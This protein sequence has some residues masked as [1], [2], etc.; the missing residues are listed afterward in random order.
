MDKIKALK[1]LKRLLEE[2]LITEEDF[3]RQKK[4]ILEEESLLNETL[5]SESEKAIDLTNEC[6]EQK[7][8]IDVPTGKLPDKRISSRLIWGVVIGV[9][10]I[11]GVV[12]GFTYLRQQAYG[13][14]VDYIESSQKAFDKMLKGLEKSDSETEIA[15]RIY[16]RLYGLLEKQDFD[17]VKLLYP[18]K[19]KHNGKEISREEVMSFWRRTVPVEVCYRDASSYLGNIV[20][21]AFDEVNN[22]SDEY[23]HPFYIKA[24]RD[25]GKWR[26][27]EEGDDGILGPE[28]GPDALHKITPEG[29]GPIKLGMSAPSIPERTKWMYDHIKNDVDNSD[30]QMGNVFFYDSSG[31]ILFTANIYKNKIIGLSFRSPLFK[32]DHHGYWIYGG[33]E[34]NPRIFTDNYASHDRGGQ[35]YFDNISSFSI[36]YNSNWIITSFN[37]HIKNPYK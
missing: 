10:V 26:I 28:E 2:G 23:H 27:I 22:S 17:G 1:E 3:N 29:V 30:L 15:H 18:E 36:W 13:G 35:Y 14:D 16:V 31:N 4:A 11:L 21:F 37:V 6:G 19:I 33:G 8:N 5:P 20:F 24:G 9:V 34:Y 12:F 32:Y 7:K 25:H